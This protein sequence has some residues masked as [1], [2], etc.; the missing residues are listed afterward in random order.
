MPGEGNL[1]QDLS[2]C[3]ASVVAKEIIAPQH[4]YEWQ[5]AHHS[6]SFLL[7]S[8]PRVYPM[9]R[10]AKTLHRLIVHKRDCERLLE[11]AL[12]QLHKVQTNMPSTVA[13]VCHHVPERYLFCVRGVMCRN[14]RDYFPCCGLNNIKVC[15]MGLEMHFE[16]LTVRFN[17]F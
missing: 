3:T 14:A 11:L 10:V 5:L 13:W 4:T 7:L 1:A 12:Q 15:M 16:V 2:C 6:V 8:F 17:F 9:H